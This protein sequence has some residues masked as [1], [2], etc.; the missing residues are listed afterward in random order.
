[1]DK[2][3][4]GDKVRIKDRKGWPTPPG[5]KLAK[6]KGTIVKICEWEDVLKEFPEYHKVRIEKTKSGVKD[7]L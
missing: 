5:Y 7:W 3:N 4:I 6:S 1:M 2:F